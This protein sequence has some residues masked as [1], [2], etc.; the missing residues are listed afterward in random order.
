MSWNF[1]GEQYAFKFVE[2]ELKFVCGYK[3]GEAQIM[4]VIEHLLLWDQEKLIMKYQK[5]LDNLISCK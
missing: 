3:T 1:L 4:E 5:Y 2:G